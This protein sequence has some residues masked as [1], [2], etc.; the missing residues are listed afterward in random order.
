MNRRLALKLTLCIPTVFAP[1]G[2]SI[3]LARAAASL[4]VRSALN[5]AGRQRMLS[6][7]LAKAW[8]M[9]G[10]G[11]APERARTIMADSLAQF[12]TQLVELRGFVPNQGVQEALA[13]LEKEWSNYKSVLSRK[14]ALDKATLLYEASEPVHIAAHRLTLA[15]ESAA[16]S[17]ADRLVNV[18]GRQRMLSQRIAKFWL[19]ELWGVNVRAA[20]ME[21]RFAHEEFS[22]GMSQLAISSH[23]NAEI[24]AAYELLNREWSAYRDA[25]AATS[26]AAGK[27]RAAAEIMDMSERVLAAC[28]KVVALYE[29]QAVAR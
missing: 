17:P 8:I 7:R 21:F 25:L 13:R 23:S 22:S 9:L 11:I 10:M 18:A 15:Y 27:K 29:Q 14:P 3:S 28:E 2:I 5:K 24:R 26:D 20:R 16:D 12:E 4:T 6:Q 1:A 19:F